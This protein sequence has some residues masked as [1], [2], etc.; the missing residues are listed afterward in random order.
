[1]MPGPIEHGWLFI[2]LLVTLPHIYHIMASKLTAV[3]SDLRHGLGAIKLR[4]DV[5]KVTLMFSRRS[6]NAGARYRPGTPFRR[7]HIARNRNSWDE[8]KERKIRQWEGFVVY[9]IR[10]HGKSNRCSI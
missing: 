3:V 10:D 2:V 1:M 6:D 4:P 5:K 9:W 8:E 7:H